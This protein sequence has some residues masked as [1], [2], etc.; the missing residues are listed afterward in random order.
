MLEKTSQ[1]KPTMPEETT[2]EIRQEADIV[3]ARKVGRDMAQA[4]GFRLVECTQIATAISELARN[5]IS[6]ADTGAVEL[7]VVQR[8][9]D[10]KG[11]EITARDSGPG[12]EDI[13]VVMRDGYS[14]SRGLGLGLPGTKRLMDAFELQSTPGN[15]VV[16]QTVK[17]LSRRLG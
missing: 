11:L 9:D 3:A 6:Y 4:L 15:G 1:K 10:S 13:E 17:W 16:V 8:D 14:T 5:I 12:I 2:I 7:H